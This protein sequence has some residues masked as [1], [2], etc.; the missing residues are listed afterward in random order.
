MEENPDRET[1]VPTQ[2][3]SVKELKDRTLSVLKGVK[4]AK[5]RLAKAKETLS[6]I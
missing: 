5:E 2:V 3:C 4:D 1:L 6:V